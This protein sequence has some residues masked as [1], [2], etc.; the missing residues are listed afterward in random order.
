[1]QTYYTKNNFI[2]FVCVYTTSD[3]FSVA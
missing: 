2:S 3:I 1:M